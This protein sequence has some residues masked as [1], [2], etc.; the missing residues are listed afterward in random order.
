[1]LHADVS[2]VK[3]LC[4]LVH[5]R[6][7]A[8]L[9]RVCGSLGGHSAVQSL[10]G[11][12]TNLNADYGIFYMTTNNIIKTLAAMQRRCLQLTPKRLWKPL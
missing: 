3:G 11:P 1:M 12:V 4:K 6:T 2:L 5:I 7:I 10:L 8:I 9:L